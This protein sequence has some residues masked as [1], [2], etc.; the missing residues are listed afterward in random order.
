MT[1]NTHTYRTTN[2]IHMYERISFLFSYTKYLRTGYLPVYVTCRF[3][4]DYCTMM[5]EEGIGF[6]T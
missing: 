4:V 6:E 1:V 5:L 2:Y 3:C